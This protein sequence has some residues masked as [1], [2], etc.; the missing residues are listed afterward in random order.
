MR[1]A[2][3]EST[4][5]AADVLRVIDIDTPQPGQGELLVKLSYS[6]VNPSDVKSRSGS[7]SQLTRFPR[8]IPHSDGSGVV[9][10]AGTGAPLDLV[11]KR[12]WLFNAQWERPFGTAAGYVALPSSNVVPLADHVP[13]QA[14][15][16]IG[17]P[18]MTAFHAVESCSSLTG[19]TIPRIG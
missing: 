9:E 6:G 17:I 13:L 4:G 19:K 3:Y 16:S 10:A 1:A 14:G 12:V 7:S 8:V 2:I 11:G 5:P 15:A 18:L